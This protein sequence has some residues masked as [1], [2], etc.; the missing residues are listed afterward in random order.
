MF[1]PYPIENTVQSPLSK[2]VIM[3]DQDATL[4]STGLISSIFSLTKGNLQ[5]FILFCYNIAWIVSFLPCFH[6]FIKSGKGEKTN[7]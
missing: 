1:S 6:C 3:P 7:K 5:L 4:V 2:A